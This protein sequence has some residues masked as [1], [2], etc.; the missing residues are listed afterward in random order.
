MTSSHQSAQEGDGFCVLEINKRAWVP[1][2]H[3]NPGSKAQYLV[4]ILAGSG[5][6][7]SLAI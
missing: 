3:S 1:N 6:N 5:K 4:K 2:V 7:G